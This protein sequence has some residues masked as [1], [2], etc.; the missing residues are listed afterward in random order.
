MAE[1]DIGPVSEWCAVC[2]A[3]PGVEC[4]PDG[5]TRV[6][7]PLTALS[8]EQ[9]E[10]LRAAAHGAVREAK[11][12]VWLIETAPLEDGGVEAAPF[13]VF[14]SD[15]DDGNR[16]I[17]VPKEWMAKGRPEGKNCD[18]ILAQERQYLIRKRASS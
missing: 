15:P 1:G 12:D 3:E 16:Y 4:R 6:W 5:H 11:G 14:V 8:K 13:T 18:I 9:A 10:L 2:G 17:S 7:V